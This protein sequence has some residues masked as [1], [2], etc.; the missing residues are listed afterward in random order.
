ME[1][2]TPKFRRD[3]NAK[4]DTLY[5]GVASGARVVTSVVKRHPVEDR[6]E[7]VKDYGPG[8]ARGQGG[9]IGIFILGGMETTL[10]EMEYLLLRQKEK[11]F[12]PRRTNGEIASMCLELTQRRNDRIK[13]FQK[14]PSEKPKPKKKTGT[15]YLPAG[16]RWVGTSEPGFK[17]LA[18]I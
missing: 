5:Y 13:Y 15:L 10:D 4:I 14:N 16:C 2:F 6:M 12:Q 18:R 1:H 11:T 8:M 9:R 3:G 7:T 17:V